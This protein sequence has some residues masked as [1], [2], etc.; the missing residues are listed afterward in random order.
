MT[1]SHLCVS[2]PN[3]NH[4]EAK[5]HIRTIEANHREQFHCTFCHTTP[6][7]RGGARTTRAT[8]PGE[9]D[10]PPGDEDTEPPDTDKDADPAIIA[11]RISSGEDITKTKRAEESKKLKT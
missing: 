4:A 8:P 9:E 1:F 11:S 5:C 2:F 6:P 10:G 7:L 3:P